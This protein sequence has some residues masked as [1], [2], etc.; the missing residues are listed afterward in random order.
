M[1][2]DRQVY[3]DG[4]RYGRLEDRYGELEGQIPQ[5]GGG[6]GGWRAVGGWMTGMGCCRIL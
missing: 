4:D 1:E 5:A 6:V 2:E 3:E